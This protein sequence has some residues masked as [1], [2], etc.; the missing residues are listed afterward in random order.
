MEDL[1]KNGPQINGL[2]ISGVNLS[3]SGSV[4]SVLRE[5]VNP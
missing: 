3:G 1:D 5:E 4:G 2:P